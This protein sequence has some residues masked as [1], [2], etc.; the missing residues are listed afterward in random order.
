[1]AKPNTAVREFVK[2]PHDGEETFAARVDAE[3][4][5]AD[6]KAAGFR[7]RVSR[8]FNGYSTVGFNPAIGRM[9]CGQKAQRVKRYRHVVRWWGEP[10]EEER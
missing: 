2:T 1:M 3:T 6:K 8:R 9:P 5:A 7:V 10:D 4:F